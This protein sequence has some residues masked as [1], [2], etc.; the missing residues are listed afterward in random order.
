MLVHPL[1]T[2]VDRLADT[3][4]RLAP[5]KVLLNALSDGMADCIA[6]VPCRSA[7]DGTTASAGAVAAYM[8]FYIPLAARLR[9]VP[10]VI[11]LV[12]G[13]CSRALAWQ[14]LQHRQRSGSLAIAI[15]MRDHRS[16]HQT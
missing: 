9:E 3:P 15:G 11:G 16:N 10:G 8:G 12:C 13:N 5:A 6:P 1:N 2:A 4:H 7:V 14:A